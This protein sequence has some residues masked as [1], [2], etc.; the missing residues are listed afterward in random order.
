MLLKCFGVR[1]ALFFFFTSKS[2]T[3]VGFLEGPGGRPEPVLVQVCMLVE[4]CKKR[5]W[6]K[7]FKVLI[8]SLIGVVPL[9][10]YKESL[11]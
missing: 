8:D 6:K 7:E 9:D 10:T 2:V 3:Q 11:I 5:L 1:G 4:Q